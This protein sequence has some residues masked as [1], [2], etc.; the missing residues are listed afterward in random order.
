MSNRRQTVLKFDAPLPGM[1]APNGKIPAACE[2]S[3]QLR[4]P[5]FRLFSSPKVNFLARSGR[6]ILLEFLFDQNAGPAVKD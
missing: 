5:F 4:P 6:G 1:V 2:G 3:A